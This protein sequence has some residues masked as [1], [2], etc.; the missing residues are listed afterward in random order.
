MNFTAEMRTSNCQGLLASLFRLHPSLV[1]ER[2]PK[3]V[4]FRL[5][6]YIKSISPSF[7]KNKKFV[8]VVIVVA[9]AVVVVTIT[10]D[11]VVSVRRCLLFWLQIL[12]CSKI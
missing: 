6:F 7:S 10:W 11:Y 3:R 5:N 12:M 2:T 9:V 8:V 4:Q 1:P